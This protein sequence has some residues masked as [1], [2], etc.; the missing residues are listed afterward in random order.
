M[1]QSPLLF[2]YPCGCIG[3]GKPHPPALEDNYAIWRNVIVVRVCDPIRYDDDHGWLLP[4]E[5]LLQSRIGEVPKPLTQI[6]EDD[7]FL[8][9]RN[10]MRDAARWRNFR[11]LVKTIAEEV[12]PDGTRE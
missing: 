1:E 7:Y 11:A 4:A 2:K 12:L 6:Q 3:L 10:T 5:R 8:F 9:L